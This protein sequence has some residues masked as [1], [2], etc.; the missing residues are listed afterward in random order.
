MTVSPSRSHLPNTIPSKRAAGTIPF[1]P[2]KQAI[3]TREKKKH[4]TFIPPYWLRGHS[5]VGLRTFLV[6]VPP[7]PP[8]YIRD[9][10][11][12][13]VEDHSSPAVKGKRRSGGS[14]D[15]NPAAGKR[16]KGSSNFQQCL[17]RERATSSPVPGTL[18]ERR[19]QFP[20][21]NL[22]SI[23]YLPC[24]ATTRH[25]IHHRRPRRPRYFLASFF[26]CLFLP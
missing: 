18:N 22:S 15:R 24:T 20:M 19:Q 7:S 6:K 13:H 14:G 1:P 5:R 3:G 16:Q 4:S 23:K 25:A 12:A 8:L 17:Q 11:W 9:S 10:N 21:E 2:T 26:C